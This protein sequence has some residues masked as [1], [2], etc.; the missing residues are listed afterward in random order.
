MLETENNGVEEGSS[1]SLFLSLPQL[2]FFI[3]AK[4]KK[5]LRPDPRLN[6][7]SP[8]GLKFYLLGSDIGSKPLIQDYLII[9]LRMP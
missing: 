2:M 4:K 1:S 7:S 5:S 9:K 8:G 6:V 3:V